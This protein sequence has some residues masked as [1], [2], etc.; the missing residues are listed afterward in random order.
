MRTEVA[1]RQIL[2]GS[3]YSSRIPEIRILFGEVPLPFLL[4]RVICKNCANSLNL[5]SIIAGSTG[6]DMIKPCKIK[7]SNVVLI[8]NPMRSRCAKPCKD[9]KIFVTRAKF[10]VKTKNFGFAKVGTYSEKIGFS[11]SRID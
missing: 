11:G 9:A 1:T 3:Q 7:V 6:S 4:A 2:K 10:F 5:L 8:L